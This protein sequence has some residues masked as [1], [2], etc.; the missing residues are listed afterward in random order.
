MKLKSLP[1]LVKGYVDAVP[2]PKQRL[3]R[4]IQFP[5]NDICNSRCQMCHIWKQKLTDQLTPD[6]IRI[7]LANPLFREVSSVGIN[8]GE[9]TLRK[10][11]PEVVRAVVETLPQIA[12]INLITNC[13]L[14]KRV[15]A[16]IDELAN[17]CNANGVHLD[18]MASLDG[19]GDVHD[20]VRGIKGNFESVV[21]VLDH[22]ASHEGVGSSRIGCTVIKE[23]VYGVEDVL[24]WCQDRSVY[25]RF[26]IGI[27]HQRLYGKEIDEPFALTW[28]ERFHFAT[29][30]D[31]L[32]LHYERN[33]NRR[34]FYRSLRDQ[35]IYN[36]PRTAG[37]AW[38]SRGVTLTYDGALAYCAVES[39]ELGSLL[40]EDA[41]ALYWSNA[42]HLEEIV[43]T[44]CATCLH[45]YDGMSDR[46]AYLKN[47]GKRALQKMPS[48]VEDTVRQSSRNGRLKREDKRLQAVRDLEIGAGAPLLPEAGNRVL[49]C[50]W[51][52]TETLGDKAIL[53]GVIDGLR[54]ADPDLVFDLAAIEPYV[55]QHTVRQMP[56]LEINE[57]LTLVQAKAQIRK[58]HYGMVVMGGGPLMA[59]VGECI[60]MLEMLTLGR[61]AGAR[62]V[63]AGCG[64]GP[65]GHPTRNTIIG[66][67][68][69]VA[70]TVFLRDEKSIALAQRELGFKGNATRI[71][72]PAFF[73]IHNQLQ[74]QAL[75]PSQPA[76]AS[77]QIL[78]ALRDW[79]IHEYGAAMKKEDAGHMKTRFEQ[80][81]NVFVDSV[82]RQAPDTRITPFCMHKL[83][84][85]GDDRAFYRRLLKQNPVVLGNLDN[86]HRPPAHDLQAFQSAQ[87]VLA[88]RFHS[89]VFSLAT[90]RPFL[91]IDYTLGGKIAGLLGDLGLSDRLIALPDFKGATA[92]D[93]LLQISPAET[94]LPV[95]I[96]ASKARFIQEMSAVLA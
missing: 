94:D 16:A 76:S 20:R 42:D 89:V 35:V 18:V 46:K 75:H 27:P 77:S 47:L 24:A 39:K 30:L 64:V 67:I 54:A 9:P 73:W 13:I 60:D 29:F 72:D 61:Q 36:K 11:L 26:R 43:S 49:V 4:V 70:D 10:D 84:V 82:S 32:Y 19:I 53:G 80:E 86:R 96:E 62:T 85:G 45:D 78:I 38:K 34:M 14:H 22:L 51:Y 31:H 87:A 8:G 59:A 88:M 12:S 55:C 40:T 95:R 21:K 91:A 23:N 6:Q 37:C 81:V 56:E 74:K 66:E 68:L 90:G 15:N 63:V 69:S 25:A 65:L 28:E 50:G 3:P 7:I 52:G 41:E 92:A 44:K 1:Q 93:Q 57:I 83:A 17:I 33:E 48:M 58:G 71:L 79:P 2:T 5:I